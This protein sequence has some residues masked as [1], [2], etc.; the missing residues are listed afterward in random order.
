MG[1]CRQHWGYS[2]TPLREENPEIGQNG[3]IDEVDSDKIPSHYYKVNWP[4]Y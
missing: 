1:H 2:L 3:I 4:S